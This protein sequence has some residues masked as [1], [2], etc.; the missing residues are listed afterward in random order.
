MHVHHANR[1]I[2]TGIPSIGE[3]ITIVPAVQ[4]G[5]ILWAFTAVVEEKQYSKEFL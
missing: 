4:L 2:G 1:V 3:A 5:T